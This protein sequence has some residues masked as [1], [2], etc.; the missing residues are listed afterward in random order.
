[1]AGPAAERGRETPGG[2]AA[3]IGHVFEDSDGTYGYGGS[4][5]SCPARHRRRRGAGPP[6]HA[7]AGLFPASRGPGARPHAAGPGRADP[8]PGESRLTS[9]VPGQKMVGDITYIE[10]WE[11]MV[12]S[13]DGH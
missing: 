4:P 8:G 7:G 3:L 13:R 12:V 2:P 1:M 10:T 5:R 11:G 9:A 6:D